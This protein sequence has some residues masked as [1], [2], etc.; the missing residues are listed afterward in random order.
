MNETWLTILNEIINSETNEVNVE[1]KQYH[2]SIKLRVDKYHHYLHD[3]SKLDRI[4]GIM[5]NLE[6]I[7]G[8]SVT[9]IQDDNSTTYIIKK[10]G[11]KNIKCNSN[12]L[13]NSDDIIPDH[14]DGEYTGYFKLRKTS[15]TLQDIVFKTAG[16][17]VCINIS[18]ITNKPFAIAEI[19]IDDHKRNILYEKIS[20]VG[21]E[22]ELAELKDLTDNELIIRKVTDLITIYMIYM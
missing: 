8:Y 7:L 19:D 17:K 4:I 22:I 1:V 10:D 20:G 3:Y 16:H 14:I 21:K 15:T 18:Y 5:I 2:T 11:I 12:F 9:E 6:N 13:Y